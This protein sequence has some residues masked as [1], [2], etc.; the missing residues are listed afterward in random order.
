MAFSCNTEGAKGRNDSRNLIF[1]FITG[2]DIYLG[3]RVVETNCAGDI[4]CGRNR[5]GGDEFGQCLG[6]DQMFRR[7]RVGSMWSHRWGDAGMV[8][9]I[10]SE[11]VHIVDCFRPGLVVRRRKVDQGFSEHRSHAT[12]FRFLG[13]DEITQVM[14]QLPYGL[15]KV[16]VL[17]LRCPNGEGPEWVNS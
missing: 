1:R 12:P 2:F 3:I 4:D 10:C 11:V 7:D 9:P 13:N 17:S 15:P 16:M 6:L 14:Q 8:L 5:R